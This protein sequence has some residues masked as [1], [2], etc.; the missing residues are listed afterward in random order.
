MIE[1]AKKA[2]KKWRKPGNEPPISYKSMQE[3]MDNRP[4]KGNR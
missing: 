3:I 1:A 2:K 4:Y